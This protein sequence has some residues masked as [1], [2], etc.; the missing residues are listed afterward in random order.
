MVKNPCA[1]AGDGA[2]SLGWQSP[3]RKEMVIHFSMLA[4]EIPWTEQPGELQS[5]GHKESDMT[6]HVC[7]HGVI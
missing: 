3:L 1:D 6:E 4:W 7:T 2:Q 5:L